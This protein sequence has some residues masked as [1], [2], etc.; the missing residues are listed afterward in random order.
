MNNQVKESRMLR[1]VTTSVIAAAALV[2][3][4]AAPATALV[5]GPYADDAGAP[6]TEKNAVVRLNL[7]TAEG[8]AECTGTAVSA[9]WVITAKHCIDGYAD[10]GTVTVGQGAMGSDAVQTFRVNFVEAAP[11]A[12]DV[13]MVHVTEDMGLAAY[14]GI[15]FN[16]VAA[17]TTATAYGWS[18]LGMGATGRLP[19]L[20]ATVRGE[21]QH[22]LY[23]QSTAY[24]T[25]SQFPAQLQQGD[26]GG[27]LMVGGNVAGVLSVGVSSNPFIPVEIS[28]TYMH[29]KLEGLQGW[30]DATVATN[31]DAEPGELPEVTPGGIGQL[32][33]QLPIVPGWA[34]LIDIVGI[35]FL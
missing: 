2:G 12:S 31:P 5:G 19:L 11:N 33:P 24:V 21:E 22:P 34:E 6:E 10:A 7:A 16:H 13:A 9:Q 35:D 4:A 30:V 32:I 25:T 27:P 15:D 23:K 20:E 8:I 29:A 1:R 28:A 3:V 18:T 14:P 26:S 17:G